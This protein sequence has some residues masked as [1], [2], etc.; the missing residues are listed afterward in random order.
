MEKGSEGSGAADNE[1]PGN[2]AHSNKEL[3]E[4][5]KK[6]KAAKRAAQKAASGITPEQ[7]KQ[8][9]E[10]KIKQNTSKA[11]TNLNLK[12]QLNQTLIKAPLTQKRIPALFSH[13]ETREQRNES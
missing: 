9:A 2:W 7:Q 12:K 5:K 8:M 6:E 10:Q 11:A 1:N 4:L 3:K 13:L